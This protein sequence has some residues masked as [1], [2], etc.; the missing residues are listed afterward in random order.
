MESILFTNVQVIDGSGRAPFTGE[1]LVIG[2]R[3]ASVT[4]AGLTS[5]A[6]A[7]V[8]NGHGATLIPGLCDA[9]THITW[10]NQANRNALRE[11]PIEEHTLASIENARTYLDYGYTMAISAAAAKPRLDFV[12][13]DAIERGQIPGPRLLANGPIITTNRDLGEVQAGEKRHFA[14][15]EIIED[16]ASMTA[17]VER[18]LAQP[19]DFIKLTM[20]G[21]EITGVPAKQTLMTDDEAAAA[22]RVAARRNVR[23]CAHAR[24]TESVKICVRQGVHLVFHASFADEELL[25][26]LEAARERIF[27]APG[28]NWLYTSCYEAAPWGLTPAKAAAM[29]YLAELEAAVETMKL[30]HARGI[31]ILPGGDYGFAWCPHGTYARDLEHCV[32]LFGFTPMEAIVSATR[33]GGEVMGRPHEL[34]QILPGY[35]ADLILVDGDPSRD[36]ALLQD[37]GKIL[38][39]M[40]GGIFHRER[41]ER[42]LRRAA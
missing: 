13:R 7:R 20:S 11:L 12:I 33:L 27:I 31:R 9:H 8:V 18:L 32:K 23:V 5:R 41:D 10:I 16:A 1:V 35:L 40:K 36:I 17:C 21:E 38:S 26:M 34:G 19:V 4:A 29:G 42:M 30:M 25:D 6:N 37:R 15:V 2:E 24:S 28:I 39:V 3:I 22:V 14:D